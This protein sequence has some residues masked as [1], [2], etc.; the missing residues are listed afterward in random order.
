VYL[1]AKRRYIN[2]L[3]FL[4]FPFTVSLT[5]VIDESRDFSTTAE[6]LVLYVS[7]VR[8]SSTGNSRMKTLNIQKVTNG[9][10]PE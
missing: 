2:T 4:S 6:S 3:P 10:S 8:L 7:F 5:I 9:V 1:G